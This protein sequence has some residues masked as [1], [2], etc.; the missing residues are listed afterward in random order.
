MLGSPMGMGMD[1][2][3]WP[4][5]PDK[6]SEHTTLISEKNW[7]GGMGSSQPNVWIGREV[8]WTL[9]LFYLDKQKAAYYPFAV[10]KKD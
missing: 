9:V 6:K 3:L 5:G 1:P 4:Q 10:T 7:S 2:E 8:P